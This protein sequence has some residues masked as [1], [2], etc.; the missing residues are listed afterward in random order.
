MKE[1]LCGERPLPS[2]FGVCV[3]IVMHIRLIHQDFTSAVPQSRAA[4][5][6]ATVVADRGRAKNGAS[7]H[8]Q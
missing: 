1:V 3:I 8:N 2:Q 4:Q 5:F 6:V 7:R